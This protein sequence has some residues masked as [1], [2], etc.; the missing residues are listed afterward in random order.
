MSSLQA[1]NFSILIG[2]GIAE[3]LNLGLGDELTLVSS[4]LNITPLGEF[5][6]QRIF[7]VG[8]IFT[9]GSQLDSSL[10]V[11]HMNDAQLL[12]RLGD[13][14]HGLRIQ[15]QDLFASSTVIRDLQNRIAGD[16]TFS[17]WTL[18]YGNIYNN[19]QLSKSMVGLLLFLL[20]AVAAFNV[21]VSLFMVVRDKQGD[22]AILRTM[23]CFAEQH[24]Q[25][26]PSAGL[27]Y[28]ACRDFCW[29]HPGCS[30]LALCQP[31]LQL[32]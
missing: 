10:A 5:P 2:A 4:Y 22:I 20:I 18:D 16:Y 27:Y 12:Y 26:L 30:W 29:P 28:C 25:Y 14:I 24:P 19:I 32:A 7:T 31:I 15:L 6:R 13:T 3:H 21:V 9:I 17:N 8:G 23:G 11:I 1:G